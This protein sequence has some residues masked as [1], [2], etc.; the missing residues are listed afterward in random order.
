MRRLICSFVVRTWQMQVFSWCGSYIIYTN[1]EGIFSPWPLTC[2]VWHHPLE[3]LLLIQNWTYKQNFVCMSHV[4]RKPVYATCE[5]QRHR[6]ACASAQFDQHLCCSLPGLFNTSTCYSQNFK[7]LTSLCSRAGRFESYL[8][9]RQVS[10][11]VAHIIGDC[12]AR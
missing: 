10:R 2:Q 1:F 12:L 6:S 9:R 3:L 4:T 11:D 7:T 8:V 5:Q